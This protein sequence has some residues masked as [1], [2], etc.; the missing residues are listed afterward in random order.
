M[1]SYVQYTSEVKTVP[2]GGNGKKITIE[3]LT[4]VLTPKQREQR[5]KEIEE[6]LF[7]VFSKYANT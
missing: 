2:F 6:K 5:K 4:P 7:Y 3:N 1:Q